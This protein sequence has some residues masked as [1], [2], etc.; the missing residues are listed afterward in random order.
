VKQAV[1]LILGVLLLAPLITLRL[2]RGGLDNAALIPRIVP[3]AQVKLEGLPPDWVKTLIMAQ[4]RIETATPEGTFAAATKVL[5]HYAALGVNGLW[6]NP[7]YERGSKG[8][9]YGNDGPHTLEPLL[10]GTRDIHASCA[11]VKR[12]DEAHR[13]NIRV[14]FDIV[15]WGTATNSPLVS[16]HPEFYARLFLQGS[17]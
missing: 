14:I 4:F 8:N 11:V 9:G 17:P 3:D 16:A 10:T 1:R 7:V 6:S 13:R 2:A 15:V 12:F 5:D